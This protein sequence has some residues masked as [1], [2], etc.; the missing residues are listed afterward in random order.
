M[1]RCIISACSICIALLTGCND[2]RHYD[3]S[4]NDRPIAGPAAL[5]NAY[6]IDDPALARCV[7][8]AIQ[9][10]NIRNAAALKQLNCSDAGIQ[11]LTGLSTFSA[12]THLKLSNNQIRNLVEVG[13]LS[14]LQSLWLDNNIVIDPVPLQTLPQL[15]RLDLTGNPRLPCPQWNSSEGIVEYRWPEHCLTL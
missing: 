9:D 14:T 10:Q 11:S 5:F 8:Q 6:D 13:Q 1:Y 15:N 2:L 7:A 3:V 12:L 4:F